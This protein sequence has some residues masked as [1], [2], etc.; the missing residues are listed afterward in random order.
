[1]YVCMYS[2]YVQYVSMY[3]CI[4]VCIS[5]PFVR[6]PFIRAR[7][8]CRNLELHYHGLLAANFWKE[9]ARRGW[10]CKETESHNESCHR[11]ERL[12][13]PSSE[14]PASHNHQNSEHTTHFARCHSNARPHLPLEVPSLLFAGASMASHICSLV[15]TAITCPTDLG[16]YSCRSPR[17]PGRRPAGRHPDTFQRHVP[18]SGSGDTS[19]GGRGHAR[20]GLELELGWRSLRTSCGRFSYYR[21]PNHCGQATLQNG[22]ETS[23]R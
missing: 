23:E 12:Q 19:Q 3:L 20:P 7:L 10:R 15:K 16:R 18:G 5:E 17:S 11:A 9:T 22:M 13:A 6:K 14:A 8:S 21:R 1:M 2:V 4:Y